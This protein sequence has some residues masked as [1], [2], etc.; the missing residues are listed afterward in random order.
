[1]HIHTLNLH[2]QAIIRTIAK[3]NLDKREVNGK[4]WGLFKKETRGREKELQTVYPIPPLVGLGLWNIERSR[5]RVRAG[6]GAA[7]ELQSCPLRH[8][9]PDHASPQL[10]WSCSR[11]Y[12]T[13][14]MM[15]SSLRRMQG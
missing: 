6:L 15:L 10:W 3:V 13:P 9:P 14:C 1:M 12:S 7:V 5:V 2:R 8:S 4:L 11:R